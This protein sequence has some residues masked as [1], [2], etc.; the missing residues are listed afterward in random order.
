MSDEDTRLRTCGQHPTL[1]D[2]TLQGSR[3]CV[4]LPASG[5]NSCG[6]RWSPPVAKPKRRC[7]VCR[8]MPCRCAKRKRLDTRSAGLR[9]AARLVRE[10]AEDAW[11]AMS[12]RKALAFEA[13]SNELERLAREEERGEKV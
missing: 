1:G 11:K 7:P 4:A 9:Q 10:R 12:S 6:L 3:A 13:V 5:T 8:P 2:V